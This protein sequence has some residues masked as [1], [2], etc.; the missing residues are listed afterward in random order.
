MTNP[1]HPRTARRRLHS[2]ATLLLAALAAAPVGAVDRA[3]LVG[4]GQYP[5]L[6]PDQQLSGIDLDLDMMRMAAAKLGFAAA[7]TKV[8]LNADATRAAVQAA[9]TDWLPAGGSAD[10]RVLIYFSTHGTQVA[11]RNGDEDDGLDEALVLYDG[12][13]VPGPDGQPSPT[14]LL[15]DDDLDQALAALPS[16]NVLVVID[17][18]HS[19][20]ATR[21]LH[22]KSMQSG[23]STGEVKSW[24]YPG[25]PQATPRGLTRRDATY[26]SIS[27]AADD[28]DSI[29][30]PRG[31]LFT[32][33]LVQ[34]IDQ[35]AGSGASLT[36]RQARDAAAAFVVGQLGEADRA[37]VF[38]PQLDGNPLLVDKGLRLV[39]VTAGRG[40]TWERVQAMVGSMQPLRIA[41][42]QRQFKEGDK[43]ELTIEVPRDG[44]LNVI[45]ID[46]R[47]TPI[48][49]FP[50]G[51]HRDH[52][53]R[54]GRLRIPGDLPFD[55][56][57]TAPYG[58]TLLVAF[59]TDEPVNLFETGDGRRD[60][61][62]N[63]LD[64]FPQ[65]SSLGMRGFRPT[66]RTNPHGMPGA[67][68]ALEVT[69]CPPT[70]CP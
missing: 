17:A 33:G 9:L 57:A 8:L 60:P 43:L 50:N 29:A 1:R 2:S 36:P 30:T 55:L 20:T 38:H 47:D 7:D 45:D 44:Y 12:G 64:Q 41:A 28:E 34:A 69:V 24:V 58:P 23:S 22:F 11:D 63:L 6:P 4:V 49:A 67:A 13:L 46:A 18:C 19:A 61:A 3:L 37:R 70:G 10:D 16:G 51:F 40:P 42:N 62:G 15:L 35:A 25:M 59:L 21:A 66:A 65:L 52:R 26:V 5:G 53:V 68:G 31:S 14:G 39:G 27:A 54:A 32:Q 56:P 48:V